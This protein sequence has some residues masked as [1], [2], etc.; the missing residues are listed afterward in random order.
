MNEYRH[1]ILAYALPKQI[2]KVDDKL[3][4]T[5]EMLRTLKVSQFNTGEF[6][7][8]TYFIGISIF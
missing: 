5:P 1:T 6:W 8:Y 3:I 7:K 4:V 2:Y